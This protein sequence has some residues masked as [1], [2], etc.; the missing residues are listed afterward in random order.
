M[1]TYC[2]FRYAHRTVSVNTLDCSVFTDQ[3]A[4]HI[5]SW[6]HSGWLTTQ[7]MY[8]YDMIHLITAPMFTYSDSVCRLEATNTGF[9]RS[10]TSV[11]CHVILAIRVVY[12]RFQATD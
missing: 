11:S 3:L 8:V 12:A 7:P 5:I 10:L 9:C 4:R 6:V 2:K 1:H